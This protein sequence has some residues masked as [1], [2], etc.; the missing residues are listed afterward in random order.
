MMFNINGFGGKSTVFIDARRTTGR[1]DER[2]AIWTTGGEVV[3]L[4]EEQWHEMVRK[5]EDLLADLQSQ[6]HES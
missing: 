5:T 6:A 2:I 3:T 4:T 1:G